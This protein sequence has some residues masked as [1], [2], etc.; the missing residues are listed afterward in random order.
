MFKSPKTVEPKA[1]LKE[2]EGRLR[3]QRPG[4]GERERDRL[5]FA[6]TEQDAWCLCAEDAWIAE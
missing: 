1:G 3:E 2:W 4:G 6:S 5:L